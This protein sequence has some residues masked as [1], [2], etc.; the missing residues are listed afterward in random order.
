MVS[1]YYRY[2]IS[3]SYQDILY[4][5]LDEKPCKRIFL[6][7]ESNRQL[8]EELFK[9][10]SIIRDKHKHYKKNQEIIKNYCKEA[11]K[12]KFSIKLRMKTKGLYQQKFPSHKHK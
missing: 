5:E 11:A 8:A 12:D 9:K 6:L 2:L 4:F 10:L 3:C 7:S 1:F